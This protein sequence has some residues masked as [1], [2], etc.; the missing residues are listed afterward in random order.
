MDLSKLR[1][2]ISL[3]TDTKFPQRPRKEIAVRGEAPAGYERGPHSIVASA[4]DERGIVVASA[5]GHVLLHLN[6]PPILHLVY[7]WSD[8]PYTG[9]G[10]ER[11][12]VNSLMKRARGDGHC[13]LWLCEDVRAI[14]R[15]ADGPILPSLVALN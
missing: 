8:A 11:A 3:F 1:M 13:G 12:M 9:Q 14:F 15:A 7:A 5:A 10:L 4:I 2:Q 6:K